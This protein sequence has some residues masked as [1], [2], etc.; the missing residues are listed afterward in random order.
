MSHT[1]HSMRSIFRQCRKQATSGE[2][3]PETRVIPPGQGPRKPRRKR[4]LEAKFRGMRVVLRYCRPDPSPLPCSPIIYVMLRLGYRT[5]MVPVEFASICHEM[6]YMWN[7]ASGMS[8]KKTAGLTSQSRGSDFEVSRGRQSGGYMLLV[9][10]N[11]A[12][13]RFSGGWNQRNT[14]SRLT[15]DTGWVRLL[16]PSAA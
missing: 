12:G 3:C 9:S 13:V 15:F 8:C 11:D 14:V 5:P 2:Y 6:D 7:G 4:R 10:G 16:I 1:Y